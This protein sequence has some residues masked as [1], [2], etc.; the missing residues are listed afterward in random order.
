VGGRHPR[1]PGVRGHSDGRGHDDG[2]GRHGG[3]RYV[4]KGAGDPFTEPAFADDF[5]ETFPDGPEE[6]GRL[7]A[8]LRA[9]IEG[10]WGA[11]A[12]QARPASRA[13]ELYQDLFELRQRLQRDSALIELVWGHGILTWD[14]GGTRIVHPLVTSQVQLSFDAET[15]TISV[16]PEAFAPHR[17]EIDMLGAPG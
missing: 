10:P 15:G 13:R 6:A 12:E 8:A 11:W 4:R 1:P 7:K 5:D 14:V 9:Y 17:M 3:R 2:C 16:E